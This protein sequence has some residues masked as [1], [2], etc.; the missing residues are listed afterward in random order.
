MERIVPTEELELKV[1]GGALVNHEARNVF[2]NIQEDLFVTP[3][4][5]TLAQKLKEYFSEGITDMTA[6]TDKLSLQLNGEAQ[7]AILM[8]VDAA[9]YVPTFE[10]FTQS[11]ERLRHKHKRLEI[12]K[13][14]Q[15]SYKDVVKDNITSAKKKL[16]RIVFEETSQISPTNLMEFDKFNYR[17]VK[18]GYK[19]F[20]ERVGGLFCGEITT[21]AARPGHGKTTFAISLANNIALTGKRVVF[22][23]VEMSAPSV[24]AKIA[25]SIVKVPYRRILTGYDYTEE[26]YYDVVLHMEKL[27]DYLFVFDSIRSATDMVSIAYSYKADVVIVDFL[28]QMEYP[29]ADARLSIWRIM[30]NL[31][32]FAKD[33]DIPVVMMSQVSREQE[34]RPSTD[35][36]L[37]DLAESS[38]IEWFSATIGFLYWPYLKNGVQAGMNVLEMYVKK[39]RFGGIGKMTFRYV[40][41]YSI[42]EG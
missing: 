14:L 38:T 20:D 9:S 29:L 18:T 30:N 23:S 31:K 35:F 6:I 3:T 13:V 24:V 32:A 5:R 26:E 28:Q 27:S 41:E 11:V 7:D 40:P 16:E 15:E 39:A 42:I 8:L 37:S 12:A 22:F 1:I 10:E 21:F 2:I 36:E 17:T 25:S 34:R 19:V 4:A 33:A